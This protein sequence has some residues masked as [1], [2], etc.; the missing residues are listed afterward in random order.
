MD[1]QPFETEISDALLSE[2]LADQMASLLSEV[3]ELAPPGDDRDH[4][5]KLIADMDGEDYAGDPGDLVGDLQ[6]AINALT[7]DGLE[8]QLVEGPEDEYGTWR[9]VETPK[10]VPAP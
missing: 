5:L 8:F 10:P 9:F 1:G 4:A 3:A 2:R 7:P 6:D